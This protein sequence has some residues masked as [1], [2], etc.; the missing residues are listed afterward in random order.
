MRGRKKNEITRLAILQCASEIFAEKSFHEVLTDDIT[1]R[2]RIGKGTLYRYFS[3][4]EELY[5]ATIVHG[6]KGMHE[7]MSEVLRPDVSLATR[8]SMLARTVIGYFWERREFF[9]LLYRHEPKMESGEWAEWQQQRDDYVRTVCDL[10]A[11][12][13]DDCGIRGVD[14]RLAVEMLFGMLRAVC[15]HRGEGDNPDVLAREVSNL[16]LN[17]ILPRG[18]NDAGLHMGAGGSLVAVRGSSV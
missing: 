10:V 7:A 1:A 4:K 18:Q 14:A 11:K 3:S 13:L 9:V 17:G 8:V 6:L 12:D 2:L 16:F 15:L 5:F